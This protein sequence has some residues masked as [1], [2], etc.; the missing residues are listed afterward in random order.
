LALSMVFAIN[1]YQ[2]IIKSL[3][4]KSNVARFPHPFR[5]PTGF[6]CFL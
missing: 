3:T 2:A 1:S 4:M 5:A 6:F